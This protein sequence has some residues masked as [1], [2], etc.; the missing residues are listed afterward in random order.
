MLSPLVDSARPRKGMMEARNLLIRAIRRVELD[1][2]NDGLPP[3][4][5]I[6]AMARE[7]DLFPLSPKEEVLLV[8]P[9]PD[10][11]ERQFLQ[12]PAAHAPGSVSMDLEEARGWYEHYRAWKERGLPITPVS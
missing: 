5:G 2:A 7:E 12:R 8:L 4:V 10:Q 3:L 1:P 6:T 11:W 9:P